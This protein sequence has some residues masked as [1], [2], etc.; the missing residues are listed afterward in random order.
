MGLPRRNTHKLLEVSRDQATGYLWPKFGSEVSNGFQIPSLSAVA[1]LRKDFLF[2]T[3][4]YL[5]DRSQ[6]ISCCHVVDSNRIRP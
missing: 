4:K 6:L 5:I 1:E 2:I 3:I